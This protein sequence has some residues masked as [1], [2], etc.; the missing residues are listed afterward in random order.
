MCHFGVWDEGYNFDTATRRAVI[1]DAQRRGF[2]F[3]WPYRSG[4]LFP[5][6]KVLQE[7]EARDRDA[8]RDRR[9]TIWGLWIAALALVANV[10]AQVA[11]ALKW[12]PF[13]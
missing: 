3:Y 4:M 9:L 8:A 10:F 6:A 7:R 5:A 13:R 11:A 1:V 12:W 2:C